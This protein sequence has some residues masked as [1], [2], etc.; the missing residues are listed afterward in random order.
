MSKRTNEELATGSDEKISA[1]LIEEA[2]KMAVGD[3]G[4]DDSGAESVDEDAPAKKKF[5][6]QRKKRGG[7][8]DAKKKRKAYKKELANVHPERAV[9]VNNLPFDVDVDTL[10]ELFGNCGEIERVKIPKDEAKDR[11]KGYAIIQFKE[12]SSVSTAVAAWNGRV[13]QK[14]RQ[15]S[16]QRC[17]NR[18]PKPGKMQLELE[19]K[20]SANGSSK[21]NTEDISALPQAQFAL[22]EEMQEQVRS[23]LREYCTKDGSGIQGKN[24]S[25]LK[26]AW[27]S[28][29]HK[30][31]E[32]YEYG[33]LKLGHA[34][35]SIKGITVETTSNNT[36]VAKLTDD[37]PAAASA[38]GPKA[39]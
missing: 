24:L 38:E 23:I 34:I 30:K 26:H 27:E 35:A 29:H 2:N 32:I 36:M 1:D 15:L 20:N 6:G 33:F 25:W 9:H 10:N 8:K 37:A 17:T 11:T 13:Y 5:K 31:F 14:R 7:N 3:D 12:E 19:E 18:G 21:E 4:G 16:V 39:D 22:P 28:E